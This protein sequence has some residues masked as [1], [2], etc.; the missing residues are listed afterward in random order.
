MLQKRILPAVQTQAPAVSGARSAGGEC[1]PGPASGVATDA[2]V[3][4]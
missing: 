3:N 2:P 1:W 4:A